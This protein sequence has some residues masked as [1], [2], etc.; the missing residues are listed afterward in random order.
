MLRRVGWMAPC[1][2]LITQRAAKIR[3]RAG[4]SARIAVEPSDD[5]T[6][7]ALMQTSSPEQQAG[8]DRRS[9]RRRL[10]R[11][12]FGAPAALTLYSGSAM[13]ATSLS[14]VARR[15]TSPVNPGITTSQTADIYVRVQVRAKNSGAS[16]STW[17]FGGDVLVAASLTTGQA[18]VSFLGSDGWYCLS[19]GDGSSNLSGYTAGT[20]YTTTAAMLLINNVTPSVLA[21]TWVALR[22]DTNGQIVGV[23]TTAGA[24]AVSR[25]C[26]TSF[27]RTI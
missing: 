26:W 5:T 23:T 11:G 24:S 9:A 22:F 2:S 3:I 15:V 19:A 7:V 25:S 21:D 17:V 10:I 8:Q 27:A 20:T 4:S 1:A 18:S 13:A 14:C 12:A 6:G 16:A